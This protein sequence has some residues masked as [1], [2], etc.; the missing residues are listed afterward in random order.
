M[1]KGS[2]NSEDDWHMMVDELFISYVLNDLQAQKLSLP[3]MA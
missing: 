2:W 1:V 3:L